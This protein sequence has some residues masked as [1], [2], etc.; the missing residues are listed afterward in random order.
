MST[1]KKRHI[2]ESN[3]IIEKRFLQTEGFFIERKLPEDIVNNALKLASKKEPTK[4]SVFDSL[5]SNPNKNKY[6]K[7]ANRQTI[8]DAFKI[9]DE[10]CKSREVLPGIDESDVVIFPCIEINDYVV[11]ERGS[12]LS[13]F[14]GIF[15]NL[16]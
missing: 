7:W 8:Y 2:Q 6:K 16:I 1:S 4:S 5:L 15:G 12:M 13:G 14:L 11:G 10:W 9:S 3:L